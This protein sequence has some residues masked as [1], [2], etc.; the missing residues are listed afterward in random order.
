M[1]K[2]S[3]N[4]SK[5]KDKEILQQCD[6]AMRSAMESIATLQKPLPR[7]VV[8]CHLCSILS[9]SASALCHCLE[10]AKESDKK[11][12][13]LYRQIIARVLSSC[14]VDTANALLSLAQKKPDELAGMLEYLTAWPA[15]VSLDPSRD[16]RKA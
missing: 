11:A 16:I 4:Q 2:R 1:A 7:A 9:A 8:S 12:D 14:A 5:A 6:E 13:P 3:S 15:V 10:N